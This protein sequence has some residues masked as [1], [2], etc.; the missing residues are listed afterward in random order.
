MSTERHE[1]LARLSSSVLADCAFLLTEPAEPNAA[2]EDDL[3]HAVIEVSGEQRAC[4]TLCLPWSLAVLVA[5]DLLG[6]APDDPEAEADARD[7]VAELA[8]VLVGSLL[9]RLCPGLRCEIGLPEAYRGEP[10]AGRSTN[11]DTALLRS[12]TGELICVTWSM[13]ARVPS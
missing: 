6:V 13:S 9:D 12:E 11:A 4:L 5:A 8:N 1:L 7:A 3:V 10:K 2:L